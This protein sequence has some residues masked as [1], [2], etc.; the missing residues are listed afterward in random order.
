MSASRR[1][2]VAL[3]LA[4]PTACLALLR[5]EM[6]LFLGP[7]EFLCRTDLVVTSTQSFQR[8]DGLRHKSI[9]SEEPLSHLFASPISPESGELQ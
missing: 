1:K 5:A 4:E 8:Q 6:N 3:G 9:T 2:G 7:P